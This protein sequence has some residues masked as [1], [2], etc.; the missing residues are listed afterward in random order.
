[1]NTSIIQFPSPP[2]VPMFDAFNRS[3]ADKADVKRLQSESSSLVNPSRSVHEIIDATEWLELRGLAKPSYCGRASFYWEGLTNNTK[4]RADFMTL[5][6]ELATLDQLSIAMSVDAYEDVVESDQQDTRNTLFDEDIRI[7]IQRSLNALKK[8][9]HLVKEFHV[10]LLAANCPVNSLVKTY[11]QDR[12]EVFADVHRLTDGSK[13]RS[14]LVRV[15]VGGISQY[16]ILC[17]YYRVAIDNND[18][19]LFKLVLMVINMLTVLGQYIYKDR[20]RVNS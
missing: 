1:M 18:Q 7:D 9:E 20:D 5:R 14:K 11:T 10:Q 15:L 2:S 19:L 16:E 12:D 3:D 4:V 13:I 17:D 6:A 8:L